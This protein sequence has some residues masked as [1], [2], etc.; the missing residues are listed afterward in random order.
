M[1]PSALVVVVS[2]VVV[3]FVLPRQIRIKIIIIIYFTVHTAVILDRSSN[4]AV[5]I[6]FFFTRRTLVVVF[7][8][9]PC[10]RI[11][12]VITVT[13]TSS[14]RIPPCKQLQERR[15]DIAVANT[16]ERMSESR[17]PRSDLSSPPPA[18]S[19]TA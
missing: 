18:V 8:I 15:T 14:M 13:K 3:V 17:D 7:F 5:I 12:E 11:K 16:R 9:T 6:P 19:I 2:V 4:T 10:D 1:L